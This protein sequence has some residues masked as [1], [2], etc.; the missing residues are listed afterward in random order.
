MLCVIRESR[1]RRAGG[2]PFFSLPGK[3]FMAKP[4]RR[5]LTWVVAGL[6]S[7]LVFLGCAGRVPEPIR[8]ILISPHRD[9]IRAEVGLAFPE[10]FYQRTRARRD[11]ACAALQAWLDGKAERPVVDH[12]LEAFSGDW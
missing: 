12:A 10:W 11:S 9:E 1:W 2:G 6:V 5:G 8:L 3:Q 7:C 4:T